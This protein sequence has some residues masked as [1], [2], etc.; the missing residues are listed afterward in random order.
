MIKK[1]LCTIISLI[2]VL[3]LFILPVSAE[4]ETSQSSETS[5]DLNCAVLEILP[6]TDGSTSLSVGQYEY[7]QGL[8]EQIELKP[9]SGYHVYGAE[10]N[11]VFQLVEGNIVSVNVEVGKKVTLRPVFRGNLVFN[12]E[13]SVGGKLSPEGTV[14]IGTGK[15]FDIVAT[16]DAGYVCTGIYVNDVDLIIVKEGN[17]YKGSF[18]APK[19]KEYSVYATFEPVVTYTATL[20][21]NEGGKV[22]PFNEEGK[23]FFNSGDKAEFQVIPDEGYGIKSIKVNGSEFSWS[24][25]GIFTVEKVTSDFEVSVEFVQMESIPITMNIAGKGIVTAAK[26][27]YANTKLVLDV[28][29]N[30][31][32]ELVSIKVNDVPTTLTKDGKLEIDVNDELMAQGGIKID[33]VFDFIAEKFIIRTI[34]QNSI[35]G[36]IT[37]EGYVIESMRTEVRK[38]GSITLTFTPDMNYIIEKVKVDGIE[39]QLTEENTFTISNVTQSHGVI[40]YFIPD[41]TGDDD[42][43]SINVKSSAGGT[44]TPSA[45]QL[46]KPGQDI[47]FV[48]TPDDGY[49]VDYILVNGEEKEFSDNSY[50]FAKVV[51]DQSLE[52]F[53]K[54]SEEAESSDSSNDQ[55]IIDI[56]DSTIISSDKF[57]EIKSNAKDKKVVLKTA[58]YS[59]TFPAYFDFPTTNSD[60]TVSIG[61]DNYLSEIIEALEQKMLES[62]IQGF[63]YAPIKTNGVKFD[64]GVML[65]V[66]LGSNYSNKVLDYLYYDTDTGKFNSVITSIN[67][68]LETTK[69]SSTQVKADESGNVTMPYNGDEYMILVVS[70]D[71]KYKLNI[72]TSENGSASPRGETFVSINNEQTIQITPDVGYMVSEIIVNGTS[73]YQEYIGKTTAFAIKLGKVNC[74]YTIEISFAPAETVSSSTEVSVDVSDEGGLEPWVVAIIIIGIAI[75]G[76]AALFIYKWNEEKDI[77]D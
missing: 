68:K 74:D 21:K 4:N 24:A 6:C 35:G 66:S 11:G 10:I 18:K 65:T 14:Y 23:A 47:S 63:D 37:A 75:L 1:T 42:Y 40:A 26:K 33:I 54:K 55:I 13:Q 62:K 77:V 60:L 73:A 51:A 9:N 59:W 25:D 53:F 38:G 12:V 44:V 15:F 72:I 50:I 48:F 36:T 46:V 28:A 22:I 7:T 27:A 45:E 76:G 57:K 43:F 3:S 64:D 70:A 49:E 29:P 61:K 19:E 58:N 30:E 20:N 16:P 41:L 34:V 17:V 31:G 52:V 69:Y 56:S 8:T 39:V 32:S 67:S 2:M 71:S 5:E